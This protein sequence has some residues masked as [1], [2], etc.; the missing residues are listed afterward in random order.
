MWGNGQQEKCH[1]RSAP[2]GT[3]SFPGRGSPRPPMAGNWLSQTAPVNAACKPSRPGTPAGYVAQGCWPLIGPL[4][5]LV[6]SEG[7][8]GGWNG[9]PSP[10]MEPFL[11]PEVAWTLMLL[12]GGS[13]ASLRCWLWPCRFPYKALSVT[14]TSRWSSCFLL[15]C[16]AS[17]AHRKQLVRQRPYLEDKPP[18]SWA[19]S[20]LS[21]GRSGLGSR[22]GLLRAAAGGLTPCFFLPVPSLK[23]QDT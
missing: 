20:K 17:P 11:P 1:S 19:N 12:C 8:P 9:S 22:G 2:C 15:L 10:G 16:T 3:E 18:S 23:P 13:K 14:P 5:T 6:P 7:R 4:S 21:W